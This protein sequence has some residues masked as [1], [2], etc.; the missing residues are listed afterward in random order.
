MPGVASSDVARI[1]ELSQ[2]EDTGNGTE[3]VE[4]NEH[5]EF[6]ENGI[7]GHGKHSNEVLGVSKRVAN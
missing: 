7:A 4:S 5:G 2:W 3:A 1:L 6:R